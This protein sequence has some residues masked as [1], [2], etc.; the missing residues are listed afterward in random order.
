MTELG[1]ATPVGDWAAEYPQTAR[2]F[3]QLQIDYCCGGDN[4]LAQACEEQGLD[5]G[6]VV[7]KLNQAAVEPIETSQKR[8]SDESAVEICNHI[9]QTHHA[10]LRR[11][12]PRLADLLD[13]VVAAHADTHPELHELRGVFNELRAE[14]E[15]H[16]AKE[17]Q[18]LFPAIQRLEQS[19]TCPSFPFGSVANPMRVME[20]DHD[21]AGIALGSLHRLTDGYR[22]PDDACNTWRVLLDG[23]RRLE[24]DLHQH[25]HLENNIL[26]P[27]ARQL[28]ESRQ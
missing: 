8:W 21:A 24:A 23:L 16:M 7:A 22:V 19:D 4:T 9:F 20:D 10:Y 5:A 1:T 6:E 11:E 17:E 13:K 15:P 27:M 18:I 2:L 28:E 3:E 26:F 25:I 12:L 14:L